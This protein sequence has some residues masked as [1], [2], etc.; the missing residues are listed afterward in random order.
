MDR[1]I[2]YS[3]IIELETTIFCFRNWGSTAPILERGW[4]AYSERESP[5]GG[6]AEGG[7]TEK[8]NSQEGDHQ[9]W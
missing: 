9:W 4:I 6:V 3:S 2:T 7:F 5:V 1:V 8:R